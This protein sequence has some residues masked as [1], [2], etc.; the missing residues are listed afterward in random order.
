[1]GYYSECVSCD[2]SCLTCDGVNFMQCLTCG[3]QSQLVQTACVEIHRAKVI[4]TPDRRSESIEESMFIAL[5]C[6]FSVSVLV[7]L[8]FTYKTALLPLL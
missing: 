4:Y 2:A 6:F 7:E 5:L 8:I 3:N 1:M